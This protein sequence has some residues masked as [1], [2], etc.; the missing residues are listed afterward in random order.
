MSVNDSL[1]HLAASLNELL[2]EGRSVQASLSQ[3][4][5]NE[6]AAPDALEAS[7]EELAQSVATTLDD[8]HDRL[9]RMHKVLCGMRDDSDAR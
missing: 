6:D 2:S 3:L 9:R 4:R 8:L 7:F 1:D 5:R